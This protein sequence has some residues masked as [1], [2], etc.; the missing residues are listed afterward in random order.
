MVVIT[1]MP[2]FSS[3][4]AELHTCR[5]MTTKC[6]PQWLKYKSRGGGTLIW[7]WAPIGGFGPIA[8]GYGRL[9]P[10]WWTAWGWG[11]ALAANKFFSVEEIEN[12]NFVTELNGHGLVFD[13]L[14]SNQAVMH[15][16]IGTVYSVGLLR[17]CQSMTN[18]LAL[19]AH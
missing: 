3:K 18:G 11:G 2:F 12:A 14:I 1:A 9:V 15:Y 6:Q 17:S 7:F 8:D 19:L 4:K 10:R 13:E 16:C 5:W